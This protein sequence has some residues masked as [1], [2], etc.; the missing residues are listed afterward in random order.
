MPGHKNPRAVI[1]DRLTANFEDGF[2]L[3]LI[4]MRINR[5][6]KIHKWLP[7][8]MAMPRRRVAAEPPKAVSLPF[9]AR[10]P[11]KKRRCENVQ[12]GVSDAALHDGLALKRA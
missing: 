2:V 5:P 7:V 9:I 12:G 10:N 1:P 11:A 4:G 6:W 8:A 3:F